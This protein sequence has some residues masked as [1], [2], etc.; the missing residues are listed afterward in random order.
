[1]VTA[2]GLSGLGAGTFH[3]IT[4]AFFKALLFLGAGSV[5]H[6]T[7]VQDIRE[8]GGL[9][10][11]MPQT[12]ITF[13]IASLALSGVPPLSG[14]W[15]KDEILLAAFG[16]GNF[17]VF[18]ILL[19]TA[20]M[21]AFYMF[22]LIFLTFFGEARNHEVH[23]HE[24]PALM[25]LPL[26]GLAVGSI[27]IGIPGSPFMHHWFQ[28]FIAHMIHHPEYEPSAFVMACSIAVAVLGITLA[29]VIYLKQQHWATATAKTFPVLYRLSFNKFY[30][31]ELYS[32]Y[33][34]KP[35][36]AIGRGLFGFD[37]TVIDGTVNGA[38]RATMFLSEIKNWI[39][40]YIVDGVVNFM[41][42]AVHFLNSIT[43]RIQTGLVQNYLLIVFLSVL[44]FLAFEL[45]LT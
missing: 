16:S 29:G 39:D 44:A 36:N 37:E 23:A 31:D 20:F 25:T 42:T 14:F 45:K 41:G 32:T 9:F 38:G 4:H 8:M 12:A 21:T 43:K 34:I 13:I 19:L 7:H 3:L 10:K 27:V 15:S 26:W 6:G 1:M 35:F 30:F 5:I 40:K 2:M 28:K 24:S 17:L 18:G 22:R 33:V 11:K